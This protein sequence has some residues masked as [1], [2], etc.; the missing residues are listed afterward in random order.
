MDGSVIGTPSYMPPEQAHGRIEEL[1]PRSDVYSVGAML[2]LLLT[3]QTPYVK[4]GSTISPRAILIGVRNGP[5]APILEIDPAAPPELVAICDQ[6][7]ARSLDDRY[8]DLTAMAEDLRAYRDN[9]VVRVYR[10]GPVAEATKWLARNRA[11][12]AGVAACLVTAFAAW[13]GISRVQARAEAAEHSRYVARIAAA[14]ACL[15]SGDSALARQHLD[16]CDPDHR[17]WEW[18]HLGW[19]AGEAPGVIRLDEQH[20]GGVHAVAF[21]PDGGQLAS[22][23]G[24]GAVRLWDLASRRAV[25]IFRGHR[26][27]VVALDFLPALEQDRFERRKL[28]ST[29]ADGAVRIWDTASGE[30]LASFDAVAGTCHVAALSPDGL[31]LAVGKDTGILEVLDAA[32]QESLLRLEGHSGP[33]ACVSFSQDGERLASGSID[34]TVLIWE[35]GS[36][37]SR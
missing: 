6:A 7:M 8:A 26:S 10:S 14:E 5:P 3:G 27:R 13:I 16:D 29:C 19:R 24:D 12:A 30:C 23:A 2:Y 9:R 36:S 11:V 22:G 20:E 17:G 21:S 18:R 33:V 32:S 28:S 31:R 15:R 34:G 25:R 4:P 37:S 1:G 35:G